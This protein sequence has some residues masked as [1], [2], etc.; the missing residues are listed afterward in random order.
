VNGQLSELPV[1]DGIAGVRSI[2]VAYIAAGTYSFTVPSGYSVTGVSIAP[3][4]SGGAGGC[5]GGGGFSSAS[6]GAGGGGAGAGSCGA[7]TLQVRAL[8][9]VPALTNLTVVVGAGG[10]GSAGVAGGNAGA[11][12]NSPS[13]GLVGGLS[14]LRIG[15][16]VLVTTGSVPI[17]AHRGAPGNVGGGG[18]ASTGAAGSTG[19]VTVRWSATASIV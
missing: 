14:E 11:N 3:G 5:G 9:N 10:V 15:G 12:G 8:L 16:N 19:T 18:T 1:G 6:G 2:R 13:S 17:T 4:A 7:A